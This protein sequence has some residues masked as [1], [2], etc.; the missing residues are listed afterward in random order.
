MRKVALFFIFAYLF[1]VWL[2]KRRHVGFHICFFVYSVVIYFFRSYMKKNDTLLGK[3][4]THRPLKGFWAPPEI[5]RPHFEND[6]LKQLFSEIL[7]TLFKC[8][9]NQKGTLQLWYE[10]IPYPLLWLRV[11]F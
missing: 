10:C 9:I 3:G 6:C 2:F 4:G 11:F 8:I 1:S 5:H 7:F